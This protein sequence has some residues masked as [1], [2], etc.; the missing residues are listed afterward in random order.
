MTSRLCVRQDARILLPLRGRSSPIGLA[1]SRP[2]P[3]HQ[4]GKPGSS[5]PVGKPQ[6]SPPFPTRIL[7]R[8]STRPYSHIS[9]PPLLLRPT[10]P[11]PSL[12]TLTTSLSVR[13]RLRSRS[14]NPPTLQLLAQTRSLTT[15]GNGFTDHALP[16]SPISAPLCYSTDITPPP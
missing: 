15:C 13:V 16:S 10:L 5:P 14:R 6:D 1:T 3:P 4:S 9:F 2:L 11:S 12:P 7:P 8:A